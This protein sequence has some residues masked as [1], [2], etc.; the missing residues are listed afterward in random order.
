MEQF[1]IY[2][3]ICFVLNIFIVKYRITIATK[4]KLLDQPNFRKSHKS[5]IP[6]I[7][8]M[9]FIPVIILSLLNSYIEESLK[10]KI[11][12]LFCFTSALFSIIGYIDDRSQLSGKFKFFL[13][14]IVLLIILPL[15]KSFLVNYLIFAGIDYIIILNQAALFFTVFCIFFFY[16][17]LNF[18]DG[19]NG[20]CLSLCIC[21]IVYIMMF[22]ETNIYYIMIFSSLIFTIIPNLMGK[23]FIGNTGVNFLSIIFSMIFIDLYNKNFL[24]FDEI[25]ILT[26]FPCID[27]IRVSLERLINK[28]SPFE[29]DKNH[30]HHLMTKLVSQSFVFV[31]YILIC[32]FPIIL[33]QLN[34]N[35]FIII[36]FSVFFYLFF[37]KFLKLK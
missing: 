30:L 7:G 11:F 1:Y 29:P 31:P 18:S 25:I 2:Y 15:E 9:L 35:S 22:S 14:S 34:I 12:I 24:K 16:N 8:F 36:T 27:T 19:L 17:S 20:I 13:I 28:K 23:L 26:L 37:V 5:P 32:T 3:L 4:L 6:S 10:L 21:W 33:F